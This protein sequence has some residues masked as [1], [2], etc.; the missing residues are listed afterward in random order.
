MEIRLKALYL[1]FLVNVLKASFLTQL[2]VSSRNTG[3]FFTNRC[4]SN[5]L[6][7]EK[8]QSLQS[9]FKSVLFAVNL[10]ILESEAE[11]WTFMFGL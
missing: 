3:L 8:T 11:V 1:I 5:K 10:Q 7:E 4:R 9:W 2:H 6:K